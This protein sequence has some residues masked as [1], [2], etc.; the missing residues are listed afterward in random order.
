[1][2]HVILLIFSQMNRPLRPALWRSTLPLPI[3]SF[4]EAVDDMAQNFPWQFAGNLQKNIPAI[5]TTCPSKPTCSSRA[6]LRAL[7]LFPEEP[8]ISGAIPRER[9]WWWSPPRVSIYC[10]AKKD[11][12]F[13]EADSL[14]DKPLGQRRMGFHCH[15][16]AHAILPADWVAL[17]P[18]PIPI[19]NQIALNNTLLPHWKPN[20]HCIRATEWHRASKRIPACIFRLNA[21]YCV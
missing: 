11:L 12:G 10:L 19:C 16:G 18:L 7:F 4:C 2:L 6:A 13:A 20:L 1:M 3:R 5:G 8:A 15:T 21:P 17:G 14:L 9:I